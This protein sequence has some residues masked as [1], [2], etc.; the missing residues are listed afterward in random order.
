MKLDEREHSC[1]TLCILAHCGILGRRGVAGEEFPTSLEVG[2]CAAFG[3]V[4]GLNVS[5]A[6]GCDFYAQLRVGQK[7]G[8][9]GRKTLGL[10]GAAEQTAPAMIER[11]ADSAHI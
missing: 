2:S 4:T 6:S 3:R 1:P 7:L 11:L 9:F 10:V 5:A 8:Q